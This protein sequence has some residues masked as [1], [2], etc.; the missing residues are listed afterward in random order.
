MFSSAVLLDKI[1]ICKHIS[2]LTL[3]TRKRMLKHGLTFLYL[4]KWMYHTLGSCGDEIDIVVYRSY[5]IRY[6]A[7]YKGFLFLIINI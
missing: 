2:Q 4:A 6:F 7:M 5:M 1:Y 3:K